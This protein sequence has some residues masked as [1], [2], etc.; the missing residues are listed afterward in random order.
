MRCRS[1]FADLSANLEAMAQTIRYPVPAQLLHWLIAALILA[2]VA[3]GFYMTGLPRNTP[4]RAFFFNLHKSLGLLTAFFI[5]LRIA[6]RATHAA[7]PLPSEMPQWQIKAA[8]L[9]HRLLY[10]CMILQ[11]L[12]GYLASS[13]S[14]YGIKFFGLELPHWGW[15]DKEIRDIFVACHKTIVIVF[16]ALIVLHVAAALKH[17]LVDRNGIFERMLPGARN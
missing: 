8:L 15:E 14:K 17:L 12:T 10:A 6:W 4:E 11:P 5:A 3:L 16:I 13:F 2:M 7:P 9:N 1:G